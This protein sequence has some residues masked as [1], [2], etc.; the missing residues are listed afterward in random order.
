MIATILSQNSVQSYYRFF[1]A[2]HSILQ[3]GYLID[4]EEEDNTNFMPRLR[5]LS[6][7][8]FE[9]IYERNKL[10]FWHKFIYLF[11]NHLKGLDFVDNF[12]FEI[13]LNSAKKW[14]RQN[15]KRVVCESYIEL[16]DKEGRLHYPN[17]CYICEG[18][19]EEKIS[20][21]HAFLPAHPECIFA[22]AVEKKDIIGLYDTK[23]TL[24]LEDNDV[25]YLFEIILKGF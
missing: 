17:R 15:P 25:E 10:L 21:M 18:R 11:A 4:F 7:I 2:R 8:P 14:D 3:V 19:L 9:W 23:S 1:G 20:L 6:H 16:L 5:N 24:Y 12:Y 13:L 22:S